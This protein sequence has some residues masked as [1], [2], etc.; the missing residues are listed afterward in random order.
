MDSRIKISP[1]QIKFDITPESLIGYQH[2]RASSGMI[3][4]SVS[5]GWLFFLHRSTQSDGCVRLIAGN[6]IS[7]VGRFASESHPML[8]QQNLRIN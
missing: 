7:A 4:E 8:D 3:D 1:K 6:S 2:R 5:A